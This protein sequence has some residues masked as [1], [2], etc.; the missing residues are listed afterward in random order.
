M[1][2]SQEYTILL[3]SLDK[4]EQGPVLN[5]KDWD[6][7]YISQTV[8]GL[9]K[10]YDISWNQDDPIVPWDDEFADRV[11]A[12]GVELALETGV[13]CLDTKRQMQWSRDELDL[14]LSL[15]PKQVTT[16]A[17]EEAV[18]V[19]ARRPDDDTRVAIFGG[20]W[21]V[22]VPEE[23]YP[24]YIESYAREPI[25]DMV[26]NATLLSTYGRMIRAGSPWEAVAGWQEAQMALE[27]VRR[28]G[29][30]DVA[31]GSTEISTTEVGEL[32]A[33]TYGGYRP[34]DV[35]HAAFISEQKVSYENLT[36]AVHIAHTQS[37]SEVYFNP[38]YG[39]YVG[40]GPGVAIAIVSGMLLV[41]VCFMGTFCNTGPTHVHLDCS[42][43]PDLVT[44]TSLAFQGLARN[45]NLLTSPFIR[46]TTGPGTREIFYESGALTMA[47]VVSGASLIDCVQSA[48][49][50]K[51]LHAS[52]LEARFCGE[53]AHAVEGMT[54]KEADPIVSWLVEKYK[55]IQGE[56]LIG[57]PFTEIY[58]LETLHPTKE[59][60]RE[61]EIVCKEMETEFG[62]ELT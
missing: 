40:A 26:E 11:F 8:S 57:Q 49:G 13:F 54:R 46:P 43:H 53:L 24:S 35:H 61:Y 62:I 7:K 31:L 16:G 51:Q 56:G 60:Y 19:F 20:P 50:N 15:T 12:A 3:N 4:A 23:L 42:T 25:F 52:P 6:L 10:K 58:D 34:T 47:T 2:Q 55:H 14:I 48:T 1:N 37:L 17:G 28:A 9:V 18:K 41:K 44:A 33:T 27:A 45:T 36:K 5:D 29:R 30:P 38:M 59:W 22:A 21:G 32:A 39:G